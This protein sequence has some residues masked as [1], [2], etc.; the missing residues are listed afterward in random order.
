[1]SG[2]AVPMDES[3]VGSPPSA[4][5]EFEAVEAPDTQHPAPVTPVGP[6]L[7][8]PEPVID[9]IPDPAEDLAAHLLDVKVRFWTELGRSRLPLAEA[10]ALGTGAIVDL[11]KEPDEDLDV[12]VNGMPFAKGKLLLVD[13]EWAIRLERIVATPQAVE[14]ASSSG[15]GA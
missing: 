6:P 1:M 12:F 5:P 7:P 4:E 13:G 8:E 9:D 3:G 11:D 14:Q 2:E 10:V 15:S